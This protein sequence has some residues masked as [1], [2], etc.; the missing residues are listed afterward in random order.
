[1]KT[2]LRALLKL[3]RSSPSELVPTSENNS[4]RK[5]ASKMMPLPR[6]IPPR[7]HGLSVSDSFHR[8]AFHAGTLAG[9]GWSCLSCEVWSQK[10]QRDSFRVQ[11]D[12]SGFCSRD[13]ESR[14]GLEGEGPQTNRAGLGS[15]SPQR[16]KPSS[17]ADTWMST[18]LRNTHAAV[19]TASLAEHLPASLD[20][21]HPAGN[22]HT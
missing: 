18:A 12:L 3:G 1:M 17:V 9:G 6:G 13:S 16:A 2:G 22:V 15:Q 11:R 5:A 19:N 21:R 20:T 10:Q 7:N 8:R 14:L 4:C